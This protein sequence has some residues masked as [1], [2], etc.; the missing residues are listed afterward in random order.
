M[1]KES[2]AR[3][4]VISDN[5]AACVFVVPSYSLTLSSIS[6]LSCKVSH[7]SGVILTRDI[8]PRLER[9]LKAHRNK[10]KYSMV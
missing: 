2:Q 1:T 5:S 10:Q 9:S 8:F 4:Y 6:G 7:V 3:I